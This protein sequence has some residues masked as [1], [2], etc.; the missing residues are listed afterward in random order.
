MRALDLIDVP[1]LMALYNI[2]KIGKNMIARE[3]AKKLNIS[4]RTA[5]RRIQALEKARE[6]NLY[7]TIEYPLKALLLKVVTIMSEDEN[8]SKKLSVAPYFL[9]ATLPVVPA[10]TGMSFYIP[11][12]ESVHISSSSHKVFI[13]ET[14]DRLRVKPDL[15]KY[16]S[17]SIID[18]RHA[19]SLKTFEILKKDAK[20]YLGMADIFEPEVK[21][22]IKP[23]F[24]WT[25]VVVVKELEKNPFAKLEELADTAYSS[26]SKILR[27]YN[28]HIV[29]F[30]RGIR[31]RDLPIYELL[32][33]RAFIKIK[34]GDPLIIR[35][36]G[37]ALLHNPLFPVYG[38]SLSGKEA[39][40]QLAIPLTYLRKALDTLKFICNEY[41]I[42]I[43]INDIWLW[44]RGGKRF[45]IPYVKWE[46][47][48]PKVKWNVNLLSQLLLSM[49][50][51]KEE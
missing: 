46:E 47:Y 9:R 19:V 22:S 29:H 2:N 15:L 37:E 36:F 44:A 28:R 43:Y 5:L 26:I 4:I 6:V 42:D 18:P 11:L 25:D 13:F 39:L 49:L 27:H 10:G 40:I 24:T 35:A 16:G 30:L 12:D 32:D 8:L 34:H 1:T 33:T 50:R 31:P 38:I 45:T 41:G 3:V 20:L 14:A 7:L 21:A 48:I 23:L 17:L 51:S